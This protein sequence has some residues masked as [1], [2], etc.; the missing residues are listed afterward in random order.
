MGRTIYFSKII[1]NNSLYE[2]FK[3]NRVYIDFWEDEVFT[4]EEIMDKFINSMRIGETPSDS[5]FEDYCSEWG[6]Q[7][8]ESFIE[9]SDGDSDCVTHQLNEDKIL[10]VFVRYC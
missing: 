6:Y 3:N 8:V 10:V 7:N 2:G 5:T 1:M 9:Y 4:Q